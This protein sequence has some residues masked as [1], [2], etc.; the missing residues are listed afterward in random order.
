VAAGLLEFRAGAL[1]FAPAVGAPIGTG[2]FVFV[3]GAALVVG[4]VPI[5]FP[6]A[7]GASLPATGA[8][9]TAWSLCTLFGEHVAPTSVVP[10]GQRFSQAWSWLATATKTRHKSKAEDGLWC[11][12]SSDAAQRC[13]LPHCALLLLPMRRA[14]ASTSFRKQHV[15]SD[16]TVGTCKS[17]RRAQIS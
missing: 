4:A 6:A 15:C 12:E 14:R 10:T 7:A 2:A 1:A 16:I 9:A 8:C 11:M 13:G 5:V 17:P 3:A